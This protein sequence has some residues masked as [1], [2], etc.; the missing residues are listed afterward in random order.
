VNATPWLPKKAKLL[1]RELEDD[2]ILHDPK[3]GSVVCLNLVA[4]LVWDLCDGSHDP[5]TIT[6][7]IA[8]M[9]QKP[10]G[11][12]GPDVQAILHEFSEKGLVQ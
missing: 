12:V 2:L 11:E 5:L 8:S 1:E 3:T 7:E 4:G 10:S 9:F 6:A